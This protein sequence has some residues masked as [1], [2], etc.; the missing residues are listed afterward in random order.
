M[1]R[2][3]QDSLY[4]DTVDRSVLDFD[5]E[6]QCSVSLSPLNI[7]ACLVC[8]KYLQGKSKS[9]H[10]YIH[11][12]QEDHHVFIN[13]M[14]TTVHV[15]PDGYQVDDPSFYDIKQVLNP[16]YTPQQIDTLDDV[17]RTAIDLSGKEYFPGYIGLNNI[18]A[19]D[20]MNVVVQMLVHVVP[21]RDHFLLFTSQSSKRPSLLV[22]SFAMLVKKI[23]NPAAFKGHVSPHEFASQVSNA[24]KKRFVTMKQSDPMD[25][26]VFLL[27]ALHASLPNKI[28]HQLFQGKIEITDTST[29][30]KPFLYL[31]IDLPAPRLFQD[32][33]ERSTVAQVT[34]DSLL[35]KYDG[36]TITND[37]TYKILE[38]P[39]YLLL[40]YKR[41][42]TNHFVKEKNRVIVNYG[43]EPIQFG[44]FQYKLVANIVHDSTSTDEPL[45]GKFKIYV[46]P[47]YRNAKVWYSIEDLFVQS[48]NMSQV[49]MSESYI[50]LWMKI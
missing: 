28:I 18:K 16:V 47:S 43:M 14:S 19:S 49:L 34:I 30:I 8:G 9:S 35:S 12:L 33:F 45:N 7:Y 22:D 26:C 29:Q 4:L 32:E 3:I 13:L 27:N 10:A 17:P 15:L 31:S 5:F 20:Y 50:Q 23:W 48:V 42:T 25:F 46:L 1:K 24:S 21:L 44:P 6:K 40:Q 2:K 38:Y 39:T 41:F 36:T 11:S 37:K